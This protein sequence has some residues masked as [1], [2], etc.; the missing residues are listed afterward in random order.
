MV[1]VQI[2]S[3]WFDF[4]FAMIG[5][6]EGLPNFAKF[7]TSAINAVQNYVL[8]FVQILPNW[9]DFNFAMIELGEGGG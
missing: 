1:F 6:G 5:A 9:F 8:V 4:K 7:S 3:I 2:L